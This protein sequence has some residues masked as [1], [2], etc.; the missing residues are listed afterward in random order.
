MTT[1]QDLDAEIEDARGL[2]FQIE[3]ALD[4]GR[5]DEAHIFAADLVE[6]LYRAKLTLLG[7]LPD[8]GS[9]W[10]QKGTDEI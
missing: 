6:S 1:A 3:F 7:D 8:S 4:N 2:L 9:R 5:I 10:Y